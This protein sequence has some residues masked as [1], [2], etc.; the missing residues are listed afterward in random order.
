MKMQ[1]LDKFHLRIIICHREVITAVS[2]KK[3]LNL[4]G[5]EMIY[6]AKYILIVLPPMVIELMMF[7]LNNDPMIS[8]IQWDYQ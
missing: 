7:R 6:E 8:H 4:T 5:N 1:K 3:W 2:C